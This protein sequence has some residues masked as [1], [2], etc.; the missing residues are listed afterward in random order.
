MQKKKAVEPDEVSVEMW[1]MLGSVN[2]GWLKDLLIYKVQ[3]KGKR[4]E[5]SLSKN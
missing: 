5:A 4:C 1:K 3:V 2:I